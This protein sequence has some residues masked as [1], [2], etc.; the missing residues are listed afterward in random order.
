[1][2]FPIA[3]AIVALAAAC[4]KLT[5]EEKVPPKQKKDD[6]TP[7]PTDAS[8]DVDA[9][10]SADAGLPHITTD[11]GTHVTPDAGQERPT[12]PLAPQFSFHTYLP[13]PFPASL[14]VQG[15]QG[16]RMFRMTCPPFEHHTG[17]SLYEMTLDA[18]NGPTQWTETS[19]VSGI[20]SHHVDLP[21]GNVMM[22]VS[23]SQGDG[24][25]IV[26]PSPFPFPPGQILRFNRM[27][28]VDRSGN[29]VHFSHPINFPAGAGLLGGVL[30]VATSNIQP[31]YTHFYD[32][33]FLNFMYSGSQTWGNPVALKTS[34]KNTTSVGTYD[35][36]YAVL[37]SVRD[38]ASRWNGAVIDMI[39]PTTFDMDTIPLGEMTLSQISPNMAINAQGLA[40]IARREPTPG[41]TIVNLS[42]RTFLENRDIPGA[43]NFIANVAFDP[44]GRIVALADYGNF[45]ESSRVYFTNIDTDGWQGVVTSEIPGNAG[46][47]IVVD[48]ELFQAITRK[49]SVTVNRGAIMRA[50]I[51]SLTPQ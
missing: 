6:G 9:I 41:F 12:L 3:V 14:T 21:D 49:V 29:P 18:N 7:P 17:S 8:F 24:F 4:G 10:S 27:E 31:D 34:G 45:G 48:G 20:V 30:G 32:G 38:E 5:E 47:G 37:S 25:H 33:Y 19:S 1:M 39:H 15:P 42:A 36:W 46:P 44:S 22:N 23:D 51:D 26:T 11:S 2:L 50:P 28:F 43:T 35:G 16:N 13:C 40:V